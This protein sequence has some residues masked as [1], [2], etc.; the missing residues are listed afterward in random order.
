M[1]VALIIVGALVAY[2][3]A[4]EAGEEAFT[5]AQ[6]KA[7]EEAEW[8]APPDFLGSAVVPFTIKPSGASDKVIAEVGGRKCM[9]RASRS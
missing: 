9:V 7:H 6:R 2:C 8:V 1:R 3:V 4:E 5:E